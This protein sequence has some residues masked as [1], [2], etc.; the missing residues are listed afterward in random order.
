MALNR[1]IA[2]KRSP[3][4]K[5]LAILTTI[6]LAITFSQ[7]SAAQEGAGPDPVDLRNEIAYTHFL[8]A[9]GHDE[10]GDIRMERAYRERET[11]DS[12]TPGDDLDL[13]GDEKYWASE[14][15][16]VAM[17]QW[18]KAAKGL[19]PTTD[20]DKLRLMRESA[21]AAWEDSKRSLRQA[22]VI[23]RKALEYFQNVN[24]IEKKT[25]VLAKLARNLERLADLKR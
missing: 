10:Q 15:Y 3:S 16:Q 8:V 5:T 6:T 2:L 25:A 7:T 13:A 22:I 20:L 18:D 24:D 17:K 23:H 21:D 14:E 9:R 19:G 12:A 4:V 1:R 11:N